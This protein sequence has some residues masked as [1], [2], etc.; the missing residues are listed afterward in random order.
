M[1]P[2]TAPELHLC[3]EIN[4]DRL[5]AYLASKGHTFLGT[6]PRGFAVYDRLNGDPDGAIDVPTNPDHADYGRRVY[7]VL[8][9]LD[10]SFLYLLHTIDPATFPRERVIALAGLMP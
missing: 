7:E 3:A 9:Y 10:G 8:E 1:T 6:D 2:Y 5:G 4:P